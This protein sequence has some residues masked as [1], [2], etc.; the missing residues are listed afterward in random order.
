MS[1]FD[2]DLYDPYENQ[3]SGDYA[4]VVSWKFARPGDSF[5]GVLVPPNPLDRPDKG[6]E[7]RR[8][9]KQPD[10]KAGE[11]GGFTVWPPKNNREKMIRPVTEAKFAELWPEED[12]SEARKVSQVHD[13]FITTLTDGSFISERTVARM[14]ENEKDPKNEVRRRL[15]EQGKDLGEK[16]QAALKKVGGKPTPGQIWTVGIEKRVPNEYGGDTTIYMV[17]IQAPTD[18]S[19]TVVQ[20][21]ID[22]A[23]ARAGAEQDA[24]D[25]SDPYVGPSAA[26]ETESLKPSF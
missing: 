3:G 18:E 6:Y 24:K 20:K 1:D 14:V 11:S 10:V 15:I 9:Y 21:Y 25:E 5:T 8:E 12:L 7:V 13:T 16:I 23:K 19:R 26:K 4:P 17:S 2:D 22:E